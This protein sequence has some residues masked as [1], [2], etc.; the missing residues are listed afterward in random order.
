M[1]APTHRETVSAGSATRNGP[2]MVLPVTQQ[3]E[4]K[5]SRNQITRAHEPGMIPQFILQVGY[6][7][8]YPDPVSL[9]RPVTS[10]LV[11]S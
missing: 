5:E 11:G 3:L 8:R 9:R 4:E 10:F 6:L 7:D 2:K 1:A